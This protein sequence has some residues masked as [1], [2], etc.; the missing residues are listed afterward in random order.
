[1]E[2]ACSALRT[3]AGATATATAKASHGLSLWRANVS[4][5]RVFATHFSPE[6]S[7]NRDTFDAKKSC[8]DHL[9]SNAAEIGLA[10]MQDQ[11][12]STNPQTN[13]GVSCVHSPSC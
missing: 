12:S 4:K 9:F 13:H 6:I 2:G 8:F 11:Y 5:R 7:L 1:M 10:G 3:V